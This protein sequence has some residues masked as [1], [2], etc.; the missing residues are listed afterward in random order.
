LSGKVKSFK[1]KSWYLE[2]AIQ[3]AQGWFM[4]KRILQHFWQI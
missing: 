4:R 3:I 2:I 1:F